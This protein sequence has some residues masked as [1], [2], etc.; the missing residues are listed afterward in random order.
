M[1]TSVKAWHY[2][3]CF[4]FLKP[5]LR[6]DARGPRPG[7]F[8]GSN[9]GLWTTSSIKKKKFLAAILS[10]KRPH[11]LM[12]LLSVFAL[13]WNHIQPGQCPGYLRLLRSWLAVAYLTVLSKSKKLN[14][15][16]LEK[17]CVVQRAFIACFLSHLVGEASTHLEASTSLSD[18]DSPRSLDSHWTCPALDPWLPVVTQIPA[19]E[20]SPHHSGVLCG[21]LEPRW[22]VGGGWP[23]QPGAPML[24]G[25]WAGP[26]VLPA[27]TAFSL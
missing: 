8:E 11:R 10:V 13:G 18:C 26:T 22:S 23:P 25:K 21:R 9:A 14:P 27:T 12:R 19:K 17:G 16:L 4:L 15:S 24:S 3:A 1:Q 5:C 20:A 2:W 7:V 6:L